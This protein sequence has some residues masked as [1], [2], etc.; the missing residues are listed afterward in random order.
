MKKF[1][2]PLLIGL[3]IILIAAIAG[4]VW[5]FNRPKP[6]P[7]QSAQESKAEV[8]KVDYSPAKSTDKVQESAKDELAKPT[9]EGEDNKTPTTSPLAV[10][11][12]TASQQDSTAVV[13]ALIDG[14]N[15][16]T[17]TFTATLAGQPTLTRTASAGVQ[18]S[19]VICQG[20]NIPVADFSTSGKWAIE[21]KIESNGNTAT[22]KTNL[23]IK[24]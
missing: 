4:G 3:G 24:K 16:G 14:T 8:N 10:T 12:S 2:L 7:P 1:K 20:F 15:S 19:Y 22:A 18:A 13:R 21:I 17:C 11:I 9:G 23:E 5:Y 6:T